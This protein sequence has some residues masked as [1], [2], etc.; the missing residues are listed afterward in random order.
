[1]RYFFECS[2]SGRQGSVPFTPKSTSGLK[3]RGCCYG[4][5]QPSPKDSLGS[6]SRR[7]KSI[8]ALPKTGHRFPTQNYRDGV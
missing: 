5:W 1:M 8:A 7:P 2:V 6:Y 4:G 3:C